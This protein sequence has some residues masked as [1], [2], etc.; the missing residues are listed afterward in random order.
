MDF[1]QLLASRALSSS[2]KE[3]TTC[4]LAASVAFFNSLAE[5]GLD[6]C[7]LYFLKARF[8]FKKD[9]LAGVLHIAY[10]G[11]TISNMIIMPT[12]GPLVGEEN[13]LSLGLF[14]GF[15][16]VYFLTALH[17]KPGCVLFRDVKRASSSSSRLALVGFG[18][19]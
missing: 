8:G 12:F 16:H 14:A 1:E 17:G 18:L 5:A 9:Q 4:S 3:S 15:L 10:V 13:L 6:I 7:L 11:A 2:A 19:K